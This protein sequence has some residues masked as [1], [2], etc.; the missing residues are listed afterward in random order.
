MSFMSDLYDKLD[1][2]ISDA[3]YSVGD[4]VDKELK[5]MFS[6]NNNS[7]YADSSTIPEE[8]K[9]M[10]REDEYYEKRPFEG[11]VFEKEV[12][13]YDK[14]IKNETPTKEG[15]YP[16]EVIAIYFCTRH[17]DYYPAWYWFRYGIRDVGGFQRSLEERGYITKE[18]GK[19]MPTEE[20]KK[21]IENNEEII[22]C[23]RF[24]NELGALA[25]RLPSE[26]DPLD[27][28]NIQS[29]LQKYEGNTWQEK[30]ENC[31]LSISSTDFKYLA[32][33][34][35]AKREGNE[36][37]AK[38]WED[39][40][41]NNKE[42]PEM[43]KTIMQYTDGDP[44]LQKEI[45][46]DLKGEREYR[47]MCY[48]HS[49]DEKYLRKYSAK[50]LAKLKK[51]YPSYEYRNAQEYLGK[52]LEKEKRYEEAIELYQNLIEFGRKTGTSI[53]VQ[54]PKRIDICKRKL[55]KQKTSIQ[56]QKNNS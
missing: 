34:N 39:K 49:Q 31:I 7:K 28:W 14:R 5:E 41:I 45:K 52:I 10:Y 38:K 21:I 44:E 53:S 51:G 32:L 15:L 18:N 47:Q 4:N 3:L 26:P 42:T 22:Y 29:T 46:E 9:H 37:K 2:R 24:C 36:E 56:S 19:W 27:P 12:I 11:T 13:E 50:V 35:L 55:E 30:L 23:H 54:I 6:S 43:Y 48:K 1:K 16:P 17:S 33:Q 20:G 40:F 25:Q 8:E